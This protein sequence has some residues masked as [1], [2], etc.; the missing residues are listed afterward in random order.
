[1]LAFEVKKA[2]A[3][4]LQRMD[5]GCCIPIKGRLAFIF[6]KLFKNACPN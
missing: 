3:S 1:M 2:A 4:E 5:V 6:Q